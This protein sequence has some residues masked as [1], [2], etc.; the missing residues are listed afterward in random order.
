[1]RAPWKSGAPHPCSMTA[2]V[3][4]SPAFRWKLAAWA[5]AA[6]G[7]ADVV[8]VVLSGSTSWVGWALASVWFVAAA[9]CA[10]RSGRV[11]RHGAEPEKKS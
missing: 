11:A 2:L 8:A 6:L 10:W 4:S 5:L 3:P 1:M 9:L 7:T